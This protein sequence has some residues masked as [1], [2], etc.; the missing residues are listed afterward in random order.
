V[1]ERPQAADSYREALKLWDHPSI[2]F[3]LALAL[4]NLNQPLEQHKHLTAALQYNGE[5]LDSAKRQRA[6]QLKAAIELRLTRLEIICDVPGSSVQMGQELLCTAPA[7][8]TQWVLPGEVTFT[9]IKKDY[10][11]N[12]RPR[13]LRPGETVTLHFRMYT[14]EELTRSEQ[15]WAAWKPWAVLGTG[16]AIAA[17]GGVLYTYAHD[18]HRR[19]DE[20][21]RN[22][23]GCLPS[24]DVASLRSRG[25]TQ[26]KMASGAYVVG[27]ATIATGMVLLYLNRSQT[28]SITPDE[29]EQELN[30][31]P[32]IGRETGVVA[33]VRF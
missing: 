28:R 26:Q 4:L 24:Q 33:T 25:D 18:N 5:P 8:F 15:R 21:I 2:H 32:L 19:F 22:C 13:V 23:G 3:N 31:A 30:I 1:A 9:T 17:G 12:I 27:G 20:E 11:S 7:R 6:Q 16:V 29:H 14:D 10:P